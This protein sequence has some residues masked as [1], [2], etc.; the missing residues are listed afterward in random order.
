MSV[1]PSYETYTLTELQDALTHIDHLK[2]PERVKEIESYIQQRLESGDI[3]SQFAL[4]NK[5]HI[6]KS[7]I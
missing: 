6:N 1:S 2:F 4:A 5:K 3:E 7:S